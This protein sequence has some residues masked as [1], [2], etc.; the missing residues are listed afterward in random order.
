MLEMI[1]WSRLS[2]GIK[3]SALMR[4][5]TH[6]SH[7][8]MRGRIVFGVPLMAKPLARRQMLKIQLPAEQAL[9]LWFFTADV[10]DKAEGYGGQPPS[11]EAAALLRLAT[12]ALKFRAT[13]DGRK[14]TGD[15]MEMRGG[16]GYVEEFVNPRLVRDAH[17]GSIWEGTSNIV[18]LDAVT[19]AVRKHDCH[20]PFEAA[21]LTRLEEAHGVPEAFKS[22][23]ADCLRR[24][25]EM[26]ASV[27]GDGKDEATCRQ[28]TS[29]FYHVTT[30]ILL[31]WEGAKIHE[32]RGDARRLLWS[33]LVL[34]HHLK[35]RDPYSVGDSSWENSLSALLLGDEPVSMQRAS[36]LIA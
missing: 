2:N 33:R 18:A 20:V 27:A 1:N 32:R 34:D 12:P 13:R 19:R 10:L 25:V 24:A 16:I 29:V 31:A 30:A 21:L 22:E 15:A 23:L 7:A 9:S 6:D 4:R 14:V 26:I 28:A 5:A 36:D 8:V 35:P 17:L 11:Q 3:S